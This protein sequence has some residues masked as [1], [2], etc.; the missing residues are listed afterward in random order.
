MS[1]P[2]IDP[3]YLRR[4]FEYKD[5]DLYWR[6]NR[7]RQRCT[8]KKAGRLTPY[9]Y[10]S[11]EIDGKSHQAHRLVWIYHFG[12]IDGL[13]DHIDGNRSNNRLENLRQCDRHQNAHNRRICRR[14]K[15]GVKGVRVRPDNGKYEARINA[16]NKRIVLGSFDDLEF[17]ELVISMAREKYHGVFANHG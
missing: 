16:L 14:N 17:A 1:A 7:G 8:G 2:E 13:I 12:L 15:T 11:V 4:L 9:G 5:G 3:A 10:V 6:V